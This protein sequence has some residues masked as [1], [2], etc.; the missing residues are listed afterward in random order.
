MGKIIEIDENTRI[1][2][3]KD[4]FMLQYK[5]KSRTKRIAWHTDGYFP[6]LISLSNEY[7]T[8]TPYRTIEGTEQ[9]MTLVEVIKQAETRICELINNKKQL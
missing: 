1:K 3:I 5:K 8:D 9:I 4:N 7:L 2:I 6:D